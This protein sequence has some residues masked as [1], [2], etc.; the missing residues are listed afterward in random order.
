MS[1][2]TAVSS[3][4]APSEVTNALV[5]ILGIGK[6]DN[7]LENLDGV[8]KDYENSIRVFSKKW[9]YK[10]LYKNGNNDIIYGK[11]KSSKSTKKNANIDEEQKEEQKLPD[12]MTTVTSTNNSKNSDHSAMTNNDANNKQQIE[13]KMDSTM[14]ITD[15]NNNVNING[16]NAYK[17]YWNS[18]EISE[19]VIESRNIWF[20]MVTMH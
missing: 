17:L 9:K 11:P 14:N 16:N 13:E 7:G 19:F 10:V 18:D 20:K 8:C 6:F 15:N 2:T 1:T 5:V 3:I 12:S 4:S